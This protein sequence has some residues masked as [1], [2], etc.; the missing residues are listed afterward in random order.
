MCSLFAVRLRINMRYD[1]D[2]Q[3]TA[4]CPWLKRRKNWRGSPKAEGHVLG[5]EVAEWFVLNLALCLFF[6]QGI[7][8]IIYELNY[9]LH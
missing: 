4:N 2:M 3:C 7:R 6:H 5:M 1:G 9:K 8:I